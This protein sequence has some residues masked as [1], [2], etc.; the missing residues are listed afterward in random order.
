MSTLYDRGSFTAQVVYGVLDS[1]PAGILLCAG[2]VELPARDFLFN[3]SRM[4]DKTQLVLI[5]FYLFLSADLVA[6]ETLRLDPAIPFNSTVSW[7]YR[8]SS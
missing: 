8:S 6:M 5:L 4:R 1:I 2:M 3:L 7:S